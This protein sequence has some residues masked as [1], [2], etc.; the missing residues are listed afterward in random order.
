MRSARRPPS[1]S[2]FPATTVPG[3]VAATEFVAWY[4]GHPDYADAAFELSCE[5]AVVIGNGNVALDVARMLVLDPLELAPTDTADHALAAFSAA[6]VTDVVVLG[7][8]GPAQATFTNPELRELGELARA[9]VVVDAAELDLDSGDALADGPARNVAMLRDYAA[10]RPAGRSHRIELRFCR[11]P[12]EIL[13]EADGPVTGLRVVR[14][15]LVRD[16]RRRRP[17]GGDRRA[18]GDPLRAGD[19]LDR[20]PRATAAGGPVRRAPR[21]DPQRRRPRVRRGRRAARSASTPPAGS[22]A[23]R[24]ASSAPTSAAPP[25][26]SR[27]CWRTWRAGG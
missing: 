12:V 11:S 15:R 18:R 25:T 16:A 27:D 20:L 3:S 8:R 14:N 6:A 23:G 4:N 22:S 2:G 21:P 5:R 1:G 26:P 19:P 24:R 9:D 7:R 17:G 10:R 13:G